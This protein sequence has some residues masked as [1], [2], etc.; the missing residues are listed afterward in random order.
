MEHC[1]N[2]CGTVSRAISLTDAVG[3][4]DSSGW[5]TAA[6]GVEL[7]EVS[8]LTLSPLM[9]LL[10]F[11]GMYATGFAETPMTTAMG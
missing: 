1:Q 7:K 5:K 9:T 10:M 6:I 3:I 2:M 11:E 8:E 4:G